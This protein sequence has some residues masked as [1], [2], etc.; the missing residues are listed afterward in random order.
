MQRFCL[1]MTTLKITVVLCLF[2]AGISACRN[3]AEKYMGWENYGGTKANT[4]YSSLTNIDTNNVKQLQV[5]WTYRTGDADTVHHSQIQ[6]NPIVVNGVLYGTSP[7]LK[8]FAVDAATGKQLWSFNPQDSTEQHTPV[9]FILNNNRGVTYWSEGTDQRILYTAGSWLFAVN[10]ATGKLIDSF[11]TKG[12]VDMHDGLGRD[13]KDLYVIATSPG[14]IYKDLYILGSRVDEGP[15]AAPGHIRAYNVRTGKQQWIF[16]TIPQPGETGYDSWEDPN[17]WK[18]TGGA[19]SWSG[20]TLDETRGILFAPTGSASP[21]FYGGRRKGANLF[22]NCLLAL[23]AATGK[24]IWH[25]QFVRHDLWDRDLPT[26]PVLV[27]VIKHDNR[28]PAVAQVTKHGMIYVFARENGKSLFYIDDRLVDSVSDL[29]GEKVWPKQP[30]ANRY[31]PFVRQEFS[32]DSLNPYLPDSSL[33]K[34]K[35]DVEGYRYGK[36]F[37]PPGKQT[38]VLLPG[39]DGGAEWGGPS[40][41]PESGMLYINANEMPWLITMRENKPSVAK[42]ENHGEAGKRLYEQHCTTCHGTDRK[43]SGNYPSLLNLQTRYKEP[44]ILSLIN[45][46]RRMMPAFGQLDDQE[47]EAITSFIMETREKQRRAFTGIAKPIDSFLTSPYSMTGYYKFLSPEGYPAIKPPWGTL[48]AIDLSTG[49]QAWKT[50]L[51]EYPELTA[52]GVPPTGTENYGGSVVTAG[53]LLFIA[54]ARDGKLRAFNKRTGQ[55][56]WEYALPAPGFATPAVYAVNGK[57]YLVIACGG[58]KLG[59]P[60]GDAYM[61]FALPGKP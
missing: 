59:T 45:T 28:I 41:D 17:A 21:D 13:V 11:G 9:R 49:A 55:L 2:L 60:S 19:N 31:R 25:Y 33:A 18:H 32:P 37:L 35:K 3:D 46:G 40:Y 56:L 29:A 54:A 20:F 30:F 8:L 52:K 39:L 26:P 23:D 12:K 14:I 44:D 7:T 38:M 27:T 53:G 22:A 1:T 50:T 61:A 34:L 10:A 15:A 43:G 48:T 24:Y 47:K 4:H 51:G 16:H 6:C 42:A 5:A 58:G 36:M 57:Q